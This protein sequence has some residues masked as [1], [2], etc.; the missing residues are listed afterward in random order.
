VER[1][2]HRAVNDPDA[3]FHVGEVFWVDYIDHRVRPEPRSLNYPFAS[4]WDMSCHHFDNLID[5][6]G[7]A[8]SVTG[9]ATRA[10]WS[11]YTHPSNTAAM[12][13]FARGLLVAYVHTHD[14]ARAETRLRLQGR[15]GA[16]FATEQGV[17]FS[18][19]PTKNF[20]TR[21]VQPVPVA[22]P[23]GELGVMAA[24]HRYVADGV[25]PG[26]SGRHNL[27]VMALC[28]MLVLAIE[29]GRTIHRGE[30]DSPRS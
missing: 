28:Q 5:W 17:E 9:Q 18:E 14:A 20:A 24:F 26:I 8:E 30:L 2:I 10:P 29:Q 7:P 19:P 27:E 25:E 1:T 3:S 4:V 12:I 6:F 16:L 22:G 13:R 11:P 23:A 15:R 21:P